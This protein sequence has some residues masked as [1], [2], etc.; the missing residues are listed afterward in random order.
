MV[1]HYLYMMTM[2]KKKNT[3]EQFFA[4][5]PEKILEIYDIVSY[6][7][8]LEHIED[9]KNPTPEWMLSKTRT[10]KIKCVH[11]KGLFE[12]LLSQAEDN[13]IKLQEYC[14]DSTQLAYS[15]MM[16]IQ[17]RE[18][19]REQEMLKYKLDQTIESLRI[20]KATQNVAEYT[21]ALKSFQ[22]STKASKERIR[23]D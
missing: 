7:E 3:P 8:A 11:M 23:C 9:T 6:K 10:L 19:V 22:E 14:K 13:F 18:K 1:K 15:N 12:E 17:L 21:A 2:K 20:A 16:M 4:S 5:I